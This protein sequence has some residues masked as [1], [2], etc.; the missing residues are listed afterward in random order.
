MSK[1]SNSVNGTASRRVGRPRRAVARIGLS[2]VLACFVLSLGAVPATQAAA[3]CVAPGGSGGCFATIQAAIDAAASGDTINVA[4]GTYAENL[5]AFGKN[6][7]INGAGAAATIISGDNANRVW[8]IYSNSTMNLAN[9]TITYGSATGDFGGGIYNDGTMSLSGVTVTSNNAG[10]GSGITNFGTLTIDG[11]TISNNVATGS[12]G[13][14]VNGKDLTITNS[15]ISGN[16]ATGDGGGIYHSGTSLTISGSTISGNTATG[17]GGGIVNF[18]ANPINITN[19][20]ISGNTATGNGGG[21][22][23]GGTLTLASSTVYGN[24][25]ALGSNIYNSGPLS[26]KSTIVANGNCA[27]FGTVTSLGG[28]LDSGNTCGFGTGP[29]DQVS[30]NP[31]LGPLANNGGP[32]LTHA[33]LTNSPAINAA[34]NGGCPATDQRGTTRPQG[35]VCDIGAFELVDNAP[36]VLGVCPPGGPFPFNTGSQPVGP[37]VASDTGSGVL[38]STSTLIGVIDTALSGIKSLTFTAVDRVGNAASKT[39]QYSVTVYAAEQK[40]RADV[41]A[42]RATVTDSDPRK[43]LD[44]AL[45]KLTEALDPKYWR[46]DGNHLQPDDGKKSFEKA[47]DAVKKLSEVAKNPPYDALLRSSIIALVGANREL[48]QIAI[49]DASSQ[50]GKEKE[51]AEAN[52]ELGKGDEYRDA[53]KFGDAVDH[54]KKAWEHA[55]KALD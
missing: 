28:N 2:V 4:A 17:N 48:A 55:L 51:I 26:S 32:T 50:N 30:V 33:L 54:Y 41:S 47:R 14:I 18:G 7:T 10:Y 8:V 13:G 38:A 1:S 35:P 37:I 36:P 40:V 53:G 46:V 22:V 25:G 45:A 6:L 42:L 39:C 11:S 21:I 29:G 34:G 16:S 24:Q 52:K 43:K 19:S 20:T 27:Q 5:S 31:L 44:E 15:T 49:G 9:M 23:N 12:G 3:L